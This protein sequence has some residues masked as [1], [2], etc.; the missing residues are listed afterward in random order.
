MRLL[1]A[2]SICCIS[3]EIC[4][5]DLVLYSGRLMDTS[6][7]E[8]IHRAHLSCGARNFV[9]L[10]DGS[11]ELKCRNSEMI[12]ISHIGYQS[13]SIDPEKLPNSLVIFLKPKQN[14]LSTVE[15]SDKPVE[16]FAPPSVHVFDF[17]FTGDTLIALTYEKWKMLR[18]QEAAGEPLYTGCHIELVN[19]VGEVIYRKAL[20]DYISGLYRDPLGQLFLKGKDLYLHIRFSEKEILLNPVDG[21]V[22]KTKI[23][24]LNAVSNT[25]WFYDNYSW[26]YPEFEHLAQGKD[27]EEFEKIRTI[28]DDFTMELFRAEYKYMS[29]YDKL[30]A[31]R[32]ETQTGIDKEIFGAYMSGFQ[33]SLYYQPLYAPAFAHKEELLIFDHHNDWLFMHNSRGEAVDSIPIAYHKATSKKFADLL[34]QDQEAQEFYAVYRKSGRNFLRNINL[35]DGSAGNTI[36]LYHPYPEKIKVVNGSAYYIYRP[37]SSLQTRHLYREEIGRSEDS[38]ARY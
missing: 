38:G 18:R 24:P 19:A 28:R 16:V 27:A 13:I 35:T 22:F 25:H 17:D 2:I 23:E 5:Q 12:E 15:I 7:Q 9:S 1:L 21:E 4:G 20:P 34:L 26:D 29:G 6:T 30:R 11:F 33:H 32:L 36:E 37:V 10:R 8:P 3:T 14:E 31:I